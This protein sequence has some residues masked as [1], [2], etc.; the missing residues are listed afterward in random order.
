MQVQ[1]EIADELR[2]RTDLIQ[3][4][5][6]SAEYLASRDKDA[7]SQ[8]RARWK[9]WNGP[10]GPLIGLQLDDDGLAVAQ[11]FAPAQLE[12]ADVRELR[13]VMAWND[14]LS[15][16]TWQAFERVNALLRN[17]REEDVVPARLSQ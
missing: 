17:Y 5:D 10:T 14:L 11:H 13:L 12:A 4:L 16:R 6:A 3:I 7:S 2:N 9:L 8:T 15:K 1:K